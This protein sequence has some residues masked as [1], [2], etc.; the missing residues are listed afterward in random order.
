VAVGLKAQEQDVAR[1]RRSPADLA[2]AAETVIRQ[3][4]AMTH[5]LVAEGFVLGI[6]P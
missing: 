5:A 1:V 3:A 2:A 6:Q 4:Q